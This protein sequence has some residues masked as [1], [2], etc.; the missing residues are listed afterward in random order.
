MTAGI[1][2]ILGPA[3][4]NMGA[5]MTGGLAYLLCNDGDSQMNQD[6]TNRDSVRFAALDPQEEQWLRRILHRHVQLT[7]SPQA[8]DLLSYSVLPMLRVEPVMPAC[9]VEETWAPILAGLAAAEARTYGRDK[10]LSSERPV[11]H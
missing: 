1:V 11:V 2:A 6:R 9:T 3:G 7:G 8:A 10:I 4:A 5:G